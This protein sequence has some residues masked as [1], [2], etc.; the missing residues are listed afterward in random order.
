LIAIHDGRMAGQEI[1]QVH[2]HVI[3]RYSFD[4]ARPVHSMF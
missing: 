1:P 2:I 3:P 4:F